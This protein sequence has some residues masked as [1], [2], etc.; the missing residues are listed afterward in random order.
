MGETEA[1]IG[2]RQ[3]LHMS[4][5]T[6]L[7]RRLR[8]VLG[9]AQISESDIAHAALGKRAGVMLDVGAHYGSSLAPFAD[10]DWSVYAFEPDPANRARLQAAFGDR[11]NVTIVPAAVSD[12]AGEMRLFTSEL[13]TGISSLAPFTTS[14]APSAIVPVVTLREFM[15][16][17]E[18]TAVDFLKIDVE[19]FERNVLDG[20]DWSVRPEVIMLEFE[21]SKTVPLGYSWKELAGDLDARGYQVLVF[22]WL[23]IEQYGGDHQWRDLARYP[24][25]LADPQGWGNLLA[26]SDTQH[27][28]AAARKAIAR[29]RV[30]RTLERLLRRRRLVTATRPCA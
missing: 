18:I 10:D 14:H 22:E 12:N 5:R 27:L 3:A 20:Y 7:K 6:A 23:P 17:A 2:R 13:S 21:D 29:Y 19:G 11:A 28:A 16:Q 26:A 4:G 9:P 1:R 30:R 24:A 25:E 8:R 15:A